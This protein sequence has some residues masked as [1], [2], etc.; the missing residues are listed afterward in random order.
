MPAMLRA[1]GSVEV[2]SDSAATA[3]SGDCV[4]THEPGH[5]E[6][7]GDT[8]VRQTDGLTGFVSALGE[9]HCCPCGVLQVEG[10]ER[11]SAILRKMA[12]EGFIDRCIKVQGRMATLEE[13]GRIHS[14]EHVQAMDL[15]QELD[16]QAEID[17]LANNYDSVFLSRGSFK[18]ACIAAGSV[19][20]L[21]EQLSA[22]TI[23]NGLAAVR[24]PG[25][26]ANSDQC[27]GFCIFNTVCV[28]A[29]AAKDLGMKKILIVDWDVHHG[30]GTQRVFEE[31]PS[32]LYFSVHRYENA[33]FFPYSKNAAPDKVGRNAGEGFNV[34]VAWN[35]K[36]KDHLVGMGDDEYLAVWHHLLLPIIAD[37]SPDL[38]LISAGFD[39]AKGDEVG[40]CSV[41]PAGFAQLT[42]MVQK[43]CP[44]VILVLEG[45]YQPA[46]VA[47]CFCS[48]AR[49]LLGDDIFMR[50]EVQPK[51][52]ARLSIERT[53]HTHLSYWPS[54]R[55]LP[56]SKLVSLNVTSSDAQLSG[57][58]PSTAPASRQ[59]KQRPNR[60]LTG[61]KTSTRNTAQRM[62]KGEI[63]KLRSKQADLEL[64]LSKIDDL[65]QS[66]RCG[67]RCSRKDMKL[68][69][70]EDELR[71]QHQEVV[72]ELEEL[73]SLSKDD[74]L[75]R[76]IGA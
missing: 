30:N 36:F 74:A 39:A 8:S 22:G 44:K 64:N 42:R 46:V 62:W 35:C 28:A 21:L 54:L 24:P 53:L 45:G 9:D 59:C 76:H 3:A 37:F 49:A 10:P 70:D 43:A 75:R 58:I 11:V 56:N 7:S 68:V 1:T 15:I 69:A 72:A 19:L 18:S 47:E 63:E 67:K 57:D 16:S 50:T 61:I 60:P 34:N 14:D 40:R 13:L 51:K 12:S 25:H 33:E 66:L 52:E 32:V 26:H 38:V 17:K 41:T 73:T 29:A 2:V 6:G 20:A 48:C 31:D 4:V 71:L 5:V 23:C 55:K 27:C 65:R